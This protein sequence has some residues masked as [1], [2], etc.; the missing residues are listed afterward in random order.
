[1]NKISGLALVLILLAGCA[2]AAPT[3]AAL[4]ATASPT[5]IPTLTP[6]P[7]P[8]PPT[9][10]PRP[11][12]T[13]TL[14]PTPDPYAGLTIEDLTKREYGGGELRISQTLAVS[15][16]FTRTLIYYP[17]DGLAIYGFMDVPRS[18]GPVPVIIALHGYVNPGVYKT[19]D[20]TTRYADALAQARYVVIHPNLRGYKPS[21]NGPNQFRVGYA[22]D[23]LNLIA[24]IRSQAGRPGPLAQ[25]EPSAIGLWGHS[26]GGGVSIRVLTVSPNVRA[27][28]LYGAMSGD[29]QEN[30]E[31]LLIW[32]GGATR[33]SSEFQAPADALQRISPIYYLDRV[34][35]AVSIH[36]G[37]NDPEVPLE[38]SL[39]LCQRLQTLKKPVECFT[40]PGQGHILAGEADQLFIQRSVAFFDKQLKGR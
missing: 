35:A 20:Y 28:V 3:P 8:V 16:A 29:E 40:Y 33:G 12:P 6:T 36:H 13:A 15:A 4:T 37:G 32:S 25:A 31:Q 11:S 27:A 19:L 17:S 26:M 38:W 23:V 2:P 10:R 5:V 24:V 18:G 34:Q 1:M 21:E 9:A 22:V 7:T 14:T 39:D 30:Y